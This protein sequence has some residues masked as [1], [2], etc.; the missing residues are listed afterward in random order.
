MVLSPRS[1]F[2][3]FL[4]ALSPCASFTR[5]LAARLLAAIALRRRGIG[6]HIQ[7]AA[8]TYNHRVPEADQRDQ[9][10]QRGQRGQRGHRDDRAGAGRGRKAPPRGRR[11]AGL[12][13][14]ALGVVYGDIG[15]SPLYALRESFLHRVSSSPENVLGVLSLI[16]WSLVIIISVKYLIFVMRADNNGEGGI[17]ALTSLVAPAHGPRRRRV[18]LLLLLGLFGTAL[19][20][21]DGM[22]TPAISVLSAVQGLEVATPAL[23]P[24]VIPITIAIL[25]G[26]FLIQRRGTGGVGRVF[27]PVT[28]LW[29]VMLAVLGVSQIVRDPRVLWA[30]D[31]LQGVAFFVRNGG[32]GFLVLG[33]VFLVVTGGEALYADMGHFGRRPIR[34]AWFAVVL[35]GLLLNYFGQGALVLRHPA[36][37]SNPFYQMAPAWA[38]YPVVFVATLATVIASQALISGAFSLAMQSVQLGFLPR[39]DIRHTSATEMGQVYVA[40]INWMLMIACVGLVLGFRTSTHLAAAYGVAVTMTMVITTLLLFVVATQLWGWKLWKAS[41]LAGTLFL[42]DLSF[43]GANLFK[44]PD[45]GWFPLVVAAG[46]FTLMTTWRRGR[47]IV[48]ER[49]R[50]TA[51]PLE[52]LL[53]ELDTSLYARV[54]GTA[55]YM[56]GD[57]ET[58]PPAFVHNLRHN[59]VLH[60]RVMFL[61]VRTEDVPRIATEDRPS[62]TD[63]GRGFYQVVL[64]YGFM[65]TARVP[66]DIA[67]LEVGDRPIEADSTSYF[68]GRETLLPTKLPGMALWRERLFAVMSRNARSATAFFHI[69]PDRVVELGIQ[70]EI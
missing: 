1:F 44:V 59:R 30:L 64:H 31:P 45:G 2:T 29:F 10:D 20:Y 37:V 43:F 25:V 52:R 60:D 51:Q 34:L 13:L 3:P 41:L 15:T 24:F 61:S 8:R 28:L 62:I 35:P 16:F 33:S 9:R 50:S 55:I 5:L 6:A 12:S 54:E 65:Q 47:Q 36:A 49:L 40:S 68:L 23:T 67:V 58:T 48:G 53:A 69:P 38:L 21:G 57:P 46:V 56:T 66:R 7:P 19:L 22:I 42:I 63:L 17:L 26:L 18:W 27:G 4:R 70:V 32:Q 11:L 39:L 14:A